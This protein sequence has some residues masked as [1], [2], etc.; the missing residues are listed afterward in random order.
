MTVMTMSICV[1]VTSGEIRPIDVGWMI[2][3]A[4]SHPPLTYVLLPSSWRLHP[5]DF[6][7]FFSRV[8]SNR[9]RTEEVEEKKRVV[10]GKT[11]QQP[12]I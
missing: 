3:A 4:F 12:E 7:D 11:N 6:F 8:T 9:R 1:V 10:M 2:S 5:A